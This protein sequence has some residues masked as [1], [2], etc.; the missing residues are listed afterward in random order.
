MSSSLAIVRRFPFIRRSLTKAAR[1]E[2][3]FVVIGI[4]LTRIAILLAANALNWEPMHKNNV[5]TNAVIS[6][7]WLLSEESGRFI[8]SPET[9]SINR[10][11]TLPES[12]LR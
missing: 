8:S 9:K 1:L 10:N 6:A 3:S 4:L 7:C 12:Q 11:R 5:A 2:M